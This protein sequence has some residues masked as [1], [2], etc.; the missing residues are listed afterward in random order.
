LLS[1]TTITTPEPIFHRNSCCLKIEEP[2]GKVVRGHNGAAKKMDKRRWTIW[3][4]SRNN[5]NNWKRYPDPWKTNRHPIQ[6]SNT[7]ITRA[8][9]HCERQ[10]WQKEVERQEQKVRNKNHLFGKEKTR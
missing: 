10:W 8:E 1:L 3:V 9:G 5:T 6:Q 7:E 2:Y 4:T